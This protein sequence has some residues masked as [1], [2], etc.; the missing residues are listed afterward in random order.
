MDVD[1]F[2]NNTY[3]S[4]VENVRPINFVVDVLGNTYSI[5]AIEKI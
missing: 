3:S 2:C 4:L 5:T 1:K